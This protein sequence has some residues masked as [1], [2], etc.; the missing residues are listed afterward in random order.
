MIR[1]CSVEIYPILIFIE[2]G[3]F[4]ILYFYITKRILYYFILYYIILLYPKISRFKGPFVPY[5]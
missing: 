3:K 2:L 4:L 1:L 5:F